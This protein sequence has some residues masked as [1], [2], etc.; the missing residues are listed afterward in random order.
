MSLLLGVYFTGL[1]FPI[2]KHIFPL[3]LT[4]GSRGFLPRSFHLLMLLCFM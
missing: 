1:S 2:F 4:S 3:T